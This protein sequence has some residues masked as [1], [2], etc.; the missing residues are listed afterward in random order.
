MSGILFLFPTKL[1]KKQSKECVW[2]DL[3]SVAHKNLREAKV[4]LLDIF[5]FIINL[6]LPIQCAFVKAGLETRLKHI[7]KLITASKFRM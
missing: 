7:F 5:S 6:P 3:N 2:M 1:E 4:S